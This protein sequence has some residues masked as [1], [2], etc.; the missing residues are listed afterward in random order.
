MIDSLT[1][2]ISLPVRYALGVVSR[3]GAALKFL[4][5]SVPTVATALDDGYLR[6]LLV[7]M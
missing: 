3:F 2:I 1:C 5:E 7:K 4:T 6:N